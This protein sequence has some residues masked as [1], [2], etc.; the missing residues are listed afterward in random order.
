MKSK[1]VLLSLTSEIPVFKSDRELFDYVRSFDLTKLK[2][3]NGILLKYSFEYVD[4]QSVLER[5]YDENV[6]FIDARSEKEYDETHIPGALNFPVLDN[7][8]RHNVGLVYK[9]YS[10]LAAVELALRYSSRKVLSLNEFLEKHNAV[11]KDIYVYC[12]RGGG[13]SKYLSSMI[14]DS[15]YKPKTLI[16]GIKSYRHKVNEFFNSGIFPFGILEINGLTGCGKSELIKSLHGTLPTL[17]LEESARHYSSL[18]GYVPYK[19]RGFPAVQSQTAFENNIFAEVYFNRKRFSGLST[20]IAESES[21]KVGDFSIPQSLYK[22]LENAPSV[23][24]ECDFSKRVERLKRDYFGNE[25]GFEEITLIFKEKERLFRKEMSSIH[26]ESCLDALNKSN[27]DVFI[28]IMLE[29]Y[30]D[31]KYKDKGKKPVAVIDNNDISEA[32]KMLIQIYSDI[33]RLPEF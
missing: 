27:A 31:V 5:L 15:G 26:Y 13:R 3:L 19:I 18:F 24:L 33:E 17:D 16:K 4:I 32:K 22:V 10:D 30:Y 20:Y 28:S 12:W 9:K 14:F 21:R 1:P 7:S 6:L 2:P 11:E 29:K 25:S 8:E 23:K